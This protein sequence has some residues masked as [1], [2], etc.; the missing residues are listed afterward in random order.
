MKGK[1]TKGSQKYMGIP[2]KLRVGEE[3]FKHY[4]RENK[5]VIYRGV[6]RL[7]MIK[8]CIVYRKEF[9]DEYHVLKEILKTLP[10][11]INLDGWLN[12]TEKMYGAEWVQDTKPISRCREAHRIEI[13]KEIKGTLF[14]L[15][16]EGYYWDGDWEDDIL[17]TSD[18]KI[19]ICDIDSIKPIG[20]NTTFDEHYL[21]HWIFK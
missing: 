15:F 11:Y 2:L 4:T 19:K 20:I 16:D 5:G 3:T 6:N 9:F 14:K 1:L 13:V 12:K 21:W 17:I 7:K 18:G 8:K 10:K